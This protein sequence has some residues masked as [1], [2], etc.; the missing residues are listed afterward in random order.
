MEIIERNSTHIKYKSYDVLFAKIKNRKLQ[1]VYQSFNAVESCNVFIFDGTN[2][3]LFLTI[4]DL[5]VVPE[6]YSYNIWNEKDRQIRANDLFKKFEF[7]CE[8]LLD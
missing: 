4:W 8:K 3:N 7:L 5:G 6:N 2:Y 1:F